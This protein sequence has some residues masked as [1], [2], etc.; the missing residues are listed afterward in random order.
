[1]GSAVVFAKCLLTA[2][3][4]ITLHARAVAVGTSAM[5]MAIF[6]VLT[7]TLIAQLTGKANGA[8]ARAIIARPMVTTVLRAWLTRA[9]GPT[10]VSIARANAVGACALAR[11]VMS[12]TLLGAVGAEG[13]TVAWLAHTGAITAHTMSVA[14]I[15]AGASLAANTAETSVTGAFAA[16][17]LPVTTAAEV[18]HQG[19]AVAAL[20]ARHAVALVILAVATRGAAVLGAEL[21][22]A[23]LAT[24]AGQ[25]ETHA[26]L[27]L[28]VAATVS[29]ALLLAVFLL[30]SLI[31]LAL[32]LHALSMA[33]AVFGTHFD[34]AVASVKA[35]VARARSIE[36][37]APERAVIG[38]RHQ[39]AV[40]ASE[41][42]AAQAL[43]LL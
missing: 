26:L 15:G 40:T 20:E 31:T 9:V 19:R 24:K 17:A 34:R 42:R 28:A 5:A 11:T 29:W 16:V 32:A 21:L 25:A 38:A 33:T 10:G 27:A 7:R 37:H 13:P 36:A 43:T 3:T 1:M 14:V 18:A 30:I 4:S 6:G 2:Q 35:L 39:A 23:V 22:E 8:L 12:T 41:P